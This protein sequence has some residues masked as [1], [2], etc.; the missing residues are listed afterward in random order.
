VIVPVTGLP[1]VI[2][3][4]RERTCIFK[5]SAGV[6]PH[7]TLVFPF[8]PAV[9]VTDSLITELSDLFRHFVR[10]TSELGEL[11]RFSATLYLAP[12]PSEPFVALSEALADRY[13]TCEPH[14]HAFGPVV[15]HLTVAEGSKTVMDAAENEIKPL[16][17]IRA[18]CESTALL[19]ETR[20]RPTAWSAKAQL[21]LKTGSS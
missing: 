8:M 15:P 12:E 1:G 16:L 7:V 4:W 5:P 6:P 17:P 11:R 9:Q 18:S 14:V 3:R 10:F 20:A 19:V 13:P 2:D 21:P